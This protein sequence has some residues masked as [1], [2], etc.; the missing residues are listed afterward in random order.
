M[1]AM[2]ARLEGLRVWTMVLHWVVEL[3]AKV[4]FSLAPMKDEKLV[5]MWA[6]LKALMLAW[7]MELVLV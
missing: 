5:Y 4:V 7:R 3:G 1:N 6:L 2:V